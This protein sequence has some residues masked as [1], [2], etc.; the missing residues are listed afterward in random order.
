MKNSTKNIIVIA[1]SVI[2]VLSIAFIVTIAVIRI[3]PLGDMK[4]CSNYQIYYN[5]NQ[6]VGGT[7]ISA[8]I[9]SRNTSGIGKYDSMTV[10]GLIDDC[11]FSV[12]ETWSQFKYDIGYGFVDNDE[13][14]HA[15][16][17]REEMKDI[18]N[19]AVGK[20]PATAFVLMFSFDELKEISMTDAKGSTVTQSFN[21]AVVV[22]TDTAGNVG[23]I[24]MYVYESGK[25]F[26]NPDMGGKLNET[27]YDRFY[28]VKVSAVTTT[29]ID[30]L[31]DIFES[32]KLSS[33][34][35]Q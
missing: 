26:G 35:A 2:A 25:L 29:A 33:S 28:P 18:A 14:D 20:I 10:E 13:T 34:D 12:F 17:G 32:D 21:S 6:V 16:V 30:T 24:T 8:E 3:Q 1:M 7:D 31:K 19:G 27:G 9:K 22:L 4:S 11:G 15:Y 23:N 5:G